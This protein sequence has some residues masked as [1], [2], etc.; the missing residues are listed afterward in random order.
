MPT[1]LSLQAVVTIG[2]GLILDA[3]NHT[4]LEL[5]ALATISGNRQ[6]SPITLRNA[7]V[8]TPLNLQAL[9][10]ASKGNVIFDFSS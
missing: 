5:Q 3:R 9:A 1:S 4:Q 10:T 2:A 6:G 8:L 7:S